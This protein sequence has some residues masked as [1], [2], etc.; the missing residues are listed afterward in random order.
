MCV[1]VCNPAIQQLFSKEKHVSSPLPLPL[2]QDTEAQSKDRQT[3]SRSM[4]NYCTHSY[5]STATKI[6]RTVILVGVCDQSQHLTSTYI[7]APALLEFSSVTAD[8]RYSET[9]TSTVISLNAVNYEL[10]LLNDSGRFYSKSSA[11]VL[12]LSLEEETLLNRN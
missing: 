3:D 8:C 4:N 7:L 12:W 5:S 1:C 11:T 6:C 9:S 10:F 2:H